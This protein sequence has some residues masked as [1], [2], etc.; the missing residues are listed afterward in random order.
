MRLAGLAV[1][2][3][4]VLSA[5]GGDSNGPSDID[6]E[7][8]W[9]GTFAISGGNVALNMVL[10]EGSGSVSGNGN[11]AAPGLAIAET[12]TGTYSAPTLSVTMHADGY[13]DINLTATV[14]ETS[15]TG[16]LNGSG[17]VGQAVT[18]NRQ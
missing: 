17:F 16:T 15:M 3:C 1:A 18:L 11:L 7:G 5:C 12:I 14:G 9:A 13:E 10:T 2:V 8:T 6:A 4:L